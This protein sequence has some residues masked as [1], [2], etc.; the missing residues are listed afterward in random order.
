[1]KKYRKLLAL[2]LSAML[3]L[4]TAG[5][6][7][8]TAD[9]DAE[10][11]SVT[12]EAATTSSETHKIGVMVYSLDDS[13][14]NM[15]RTY[16]RDYLGEA[17]DT[18]FVYSEAISTIDDEKA[19]VDQCKEQGCEGMIAFM[20][21]DLQTLVDYCGED[22]YLALANMT[23]EQADFDAVKDKKQFLGVISAGDEEEYKAG[24]SVVEDLTE[25]NID[26]SKEWLLFT[27][28]ASMD[29]YMHEQ[30]LQGMLDTLVEAGY[31]LTSTIDE[32]KSTMEPVQAAESDQGGKI[33][34]CPGYPDAFPENITKA[35]EMSQPDYIGAVCTIE[36]VLDEI[37]AKEKA[38]DKDV[39]IGVVDCFSEANAEAYAEKDGYGNSSINCVIGKCQAMGAPSFVAVYNAI[40][41]YEDAMRDNGSAYWLQQYFW[42]ADSE[43]DYQEMMTKANNIYTNLYATEDLM[44]VLGVYTENVSFADFESFVD[45]INQ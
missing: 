38:M 15:F 23:P 5:C 41:G 31:T 18:E 14:V 22:F 42:D 21:N 11:A 24:A 20:T 13:E 4:T 3:T 36:D 40:T 19:F 45:Q 30:R 27:G 9:T 28:G 39:R 6:A 8:Q 2:G 43:E 10:G 29:N 35:L 7:S 1:M 32:L 25:E 37:L 12:T 33:Y 34:V 44:A 16:Y 17:F 26:T